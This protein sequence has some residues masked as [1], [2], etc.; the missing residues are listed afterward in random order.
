MTVKT[1]SITVGIASI[2]L[3]FALLLNA[4]MAQDPG[5]SAKV[6][7]AKPGQTRLI[8]SNGLRAPLE[9]IKEDAE[10]AVGHSFIIEYGA[11]LALKNTIESG[12]PFEVAIVTPEVL[13]E[14][15]SKGKVVAGSR[16][17]VARVPVAIGQRGEGPKQDISTPD[18]LKKA[19][20][21]AKSIRYATNGASLPTVNKMIDQLGIAS[22]MKDKTNQQGVQLGAGEYELN[23]N[24]ASEILPVKTQVYLG[25]IPKEF[26]I[27]AIMAAGIGSSGDQAAAKALMKFLQGPAIE[28]SLKANGMQR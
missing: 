4:V 22:Q 24:L 9:A 6:A 15:T 12:Q 11:S 25:N 20:L 1:K 3:V 13:D 16:F 14:M 7:D 18:A 5:P 27:P 17:D 2:G 23:I 28:P 21:N 10:K 8:V 26:Q 19:L